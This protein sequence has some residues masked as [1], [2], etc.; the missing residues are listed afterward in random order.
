KMNDLVTLRTPGAQSPGE[1]YRLAVRVLRTYGVA[2]RYEGGRVLFVP[3]TKGAEFEP[4]LV[5][6]GRALPSVPIT[7]R[8][9]FQLVELKAVRVA[10][11]VQWLRTGFKTEDLQVVEDLN[12]NAVVLYGKPDVVRNAASAIEVFDRPYM[13]GR[14]STRLEPAFVS[15]DE[16]SRRLV[17]VLVAE[18]YGASL[19]TGAGVVQAASVIVLPIG[20]ANTV[21]IFAADRG[22]LEHAV[23]WARTIDQPNPTAGAEGLFYYR[24]QNTKAEDIVATI[25]GV[26]AASDTRAPARDAVSSAGVAQPANA[27]PAVAAGGA[28]GSALAKGNLVLDA[29]RNALIFQ[30]SGSEWGRLL[31]LIKQM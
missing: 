5:L 26:R 16:L 12:R 21:L 14:V 18:G 23:Q 19:H 25:R 8:P 29:P 15:A 17:D 4:P 6:S 2:T 28:G 1:F 9:I 20:A 3:A 7:H 24:V 10:D 27:P 31:P 30:G 22:V 13:R 11:V